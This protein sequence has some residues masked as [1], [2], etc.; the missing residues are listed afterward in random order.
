MS[1]E[2]K[3]YVIRLDDYFIQ[4]GMSTYRA[5]RKFLRNNNVLINGNVVI[6]SGYPLNTK[7]DE[8]FVNGEKILLHSHLYLMMNKK[9]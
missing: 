1:G 6:D 4:N 8:L 7:E 3:P 5:V 9:T 2:K